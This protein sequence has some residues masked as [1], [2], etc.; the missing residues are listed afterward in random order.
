MKKCKICRGKYH[1]RCWHQ[2]TKYVI[3]H[4]MEYIAVKCPEKSSNSTSSFSSK[5]KL[6]YIEKV[7]YHAISKIQVSQVLA[8][9]LVGSRFWNLVTSVIIDSGTT[10]HI[11]NNRDLFSIYRKYEH[12]FKT[13]QKSTFSNIVTAMST[14]E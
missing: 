13:K 3:C 2:M 11:F 6:C 8:L 14:W 5:K 1:K 9:F 7:T 10:N 12:Q 4:N